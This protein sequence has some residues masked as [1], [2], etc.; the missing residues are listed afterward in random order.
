MVTRWSDCQ[1]LGSDGSAMPRASHVL[2][3]SG[4]GYG[5]VVNVFIG[6]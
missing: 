2:G 3:A 1:R 6:I 5:C 4:G